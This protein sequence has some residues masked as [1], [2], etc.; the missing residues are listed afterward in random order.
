MLAVTK[1]TS[2]L[3]VIGLL[4][5]PALAQDATTPTPTPDAATDAPT[6]DADTAPADNVGGLSLGEDPNSTPQVGQTY[7][8][9]EIG[10]WALQCVKSEEGEEEP[11][12]LY[13]LLRD[14]TDNPVAEIVLFRISGGGQAVAGA[15]VVAPLQTLLPS[16]ILLSVDDG[17][18]KK[19]PFSVCSRV[20][21]VARIGLT[22][23]EVN[24]MKN[25]KQANIVIR[26]FNAPDIEVKLPASLIGFTAGFEKTTEMPIGEQ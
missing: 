18:P 2:A 1:F 4:A 17:Q 19:Y 20:G 24:A 12:Q 25:G 11:C 3:A 14:E 13:Q 16:G 15:S 7:I 26:P 5:G 8:K 9:E 23:A 21:C 6:T 10:D 22:Q